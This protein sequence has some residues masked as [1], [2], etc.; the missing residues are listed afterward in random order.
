MCQVFESLWP[1]LYVLVKVN[2]GKGKSLK[3]PVDFIPF[4]DVL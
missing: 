3:G 2:C 4:Q 1:P